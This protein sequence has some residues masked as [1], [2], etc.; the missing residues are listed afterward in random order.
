[1]PVEAGAVG[2]HRLVLEDRC[3]PDGRDTEI[4][5]IGQGHHDAAQVAAVIIALMGGEVAMPQDIFSGK[6]LPLIAAKVV[7]GVSIQESVGHDEIDDFVLWGTVDG[8]GDKGGSRQK[9]RCY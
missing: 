4:L 2:L 6:A 1:M 5:Q 8:G 7:G 3:Q 9:G